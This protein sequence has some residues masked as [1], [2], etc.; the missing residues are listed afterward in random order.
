MPF[1]QNIQPEWLLQEY[2]QEMPAE[3]RT[4]HRNVSGQAQ[5]EW[6]AKEFQQEQGIRR[7]TE[8]MRR[9][10]ERQNNSSS[11]LTGPPIEIEIIPATTGVP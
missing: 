2:R 7:Q 5:I 4:H 8:E 1:P 10:I 9:R 6:T 3:L 11:G